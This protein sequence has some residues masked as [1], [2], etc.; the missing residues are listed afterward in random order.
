VLPVTLAGARSALAFAT[1]RDGGRSWRI[2]ATVPARRPVATTS[3]IPSAVVDGDDWL[4]AFEGGRRL[5]AARGGG[6]AIV[7]PAAWSR[8]LGVA[9]AP[10]SALRF[11][12]ATTGWA[13]VGAACKVFRQPRCRDPR[14]L[15]GTTDGGVTWRRLTPP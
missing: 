12:S 7:Q 3:Q 1:T 15:F 9:S 13:H 5:V 6:S 10:V 2:A 4:G 11:A 8:P 14:A